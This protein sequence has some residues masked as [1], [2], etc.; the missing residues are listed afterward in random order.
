MTLHFM[1]TPT[2]NA[3]P[4]VIVVGGGPA[5]LAAAA[6]A[7]ELGLSA[8]LIEK[9]TRLG[10]QLPV[11]AGRFSAADTRLQ[12]R[13]GISD[14]PDEHFEDVM[15]LGG[16]KASP[17]LLRRAVD[18]AA[19]SVDWLESLG[20]PFARGAPATVTYHEPYSK[21]RTYWGF[22]GGRPAGIAVLECL[23]GS[24]LLD[25][26]DVRL[27]SRVT[28]IHLEEGSHIARVSGV[29]VTG[30]SRKVATL[31]ARNV[32]VATGGYA[33][34]RDLVAEL[35]PG[36]AS[37]ITACLD[38]ATGDGLRLLRDLGV[39]ITHTDTYVPSMGLIPDPARPG[40]AIPLPEAQVIV[41]AAEREPWEIWVNADGERF[42]AEDDPSPSN[43]EAAFRAQPGQAMY[44]LWDQAIGESAPPVLRGS[45]VDG[46]PTESLNVPW[47]IREDSL[48]DLAARCNLPRDAFLS[49]VA[50]YN[51]IDHPDVLG[52]G[53]RARPLGVPPF[54]AVLS[55]GALLV[56]WGGPRVDEELR[57]VTTDSGP[58]RGLYAVG[59]LLGMGQL[60]GEVLAGGMGVGPA[61][62]LGRTVVKAI[63]A[64]GRSA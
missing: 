4:D 62:A 8:V 41:D 61:L 30:P 1:T 33:A 45:L 64:A 36:D 51:D 13:R 19:E 42:I 29:D 17:K 2:R 60:C 35:H 39:P 32:I 22:A 48:A 16:H 58:I 40:F 49:T 56:S 37:A 6:T 7:T 15:R 5:G 47:L 38:H 52:R 3:D 20:F 18:V 10:G 23:T 12:R 59:E 46:L 63:A 54:S 27:E 11:S 34:N 9:T 28:A 50:S 31:T 43:R 14:S 53:H 57:P 21:P 24:G 44:V 26:V 55:A 25:D